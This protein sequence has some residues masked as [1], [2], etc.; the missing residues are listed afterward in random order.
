MPAHE[1]RLIVESTDGG[2]TWTSVAEEPGMVENG[3]TSAIYFIDTGNA[4]TTRKTFLRIA[5]QKADSGTWRTE[6]SGTHWDWVDGNEHA[7]GS[8]GIYQTGNGV[9]YMGGAYSDLGWGVLRSA[10]YGRSWLHVGNGSP[11]STVFGT[12]KY[13]YSTAGWS[14]LSAT[15]DPSLELAAQPGTGTWTTPGTPTE[16]RMGP[17]QVAVTN[18]GK[19]NIIVSANGGAGLW[20]YVEP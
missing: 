5:Q 6:N 3:G 1:E 15:I 4:A 13:V 19:N 2:Q 7:H 8:S 9:I 16:M 20:R 14:A 12:S 11:N 17:G 18:D 10:D